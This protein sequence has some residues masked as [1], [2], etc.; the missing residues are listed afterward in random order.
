MSLLPRGI[1]SS[2]IVF[3]FIACAPAEQGIGLVFDA[4]EPLALIPPADASPSEMSS[5]ARGLEYWNGLA[6][7]R[8]EMASEGS[9]AANSIPLEFDTAAS[10]FFGLYDDENGRVI[11]N[12]A[13]MDADKRAVTVAH[14][15][16]HA[17]GLIHVDRDS[18][19]SVMNT[20]N[21]DVPP[22]ESDAR[23]L[24]ALWGDCSD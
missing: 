16:G 14:E 13:L 7:T 23:A 17:M 5:I 10:N 2:F 9:A 11:V 1:A 21:T 8:L 12:R 3:S 24:R 4:C 18:R 20:G 15:L 6:N 22:N 19:A